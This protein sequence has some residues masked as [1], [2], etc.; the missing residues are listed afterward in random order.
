MS[1]TPARLVRPRWNLPSIRPT[2][3]TWRVG[4]QC[5]DRIDE[6]L[7]GDDKEVDGPWEKRVRKLDVS[8]PTPTVKTR[9]G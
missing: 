3:W 5:E 1:V 2:I 7:L 4:D 9:P 6:G 8:S